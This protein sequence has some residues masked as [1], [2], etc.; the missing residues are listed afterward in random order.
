LSYLLGKK[1]TAVTP[2]R[3]AG[4]MEV[5][6]SRFDVVSEGSYVPAGAPVEVVKVEGRRI[7]VRTG[8]RF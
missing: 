6:G 8:D 2:L 3:P 5:E 1:G 4:I 7:V